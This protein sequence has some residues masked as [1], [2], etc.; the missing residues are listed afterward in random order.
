VGPHQWAAC[1]A[2]R[3][4]FENV[5]HVLDRLPEGDFEYAK[6]RDGPELAVG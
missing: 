3:F 1:Q 4:F 6:D 2:D 5:Q